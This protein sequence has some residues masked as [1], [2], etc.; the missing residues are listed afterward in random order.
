MA[1]SLLVSGQGRWHYHQAM[2]RPILYVSSLRYSSWS[3]RALLPLLHARADVEV[4]TVTLEM[5]RQGDRESEVDAEH[6]ERLAA[7]RLAARRALG[8]VTGYFPVLDVDGAQIHE[9]LAICEWAAE[10]YPEAGLWPGDA[11]A[12]A[13][14]RAL[15]AEMASNFINLRH[16]MSCHV[17]A[18]VPGFV[19][20]GPTRVEIKRVFELMRNA[21]SV[22][23]G[24]F[25]FGDFSIVDA[26]Y[27]PVLTRFETYGVAL[28]PELH[29][30]ADAMM[31]SPSVLRWRELARRA[32]AIPIYSCLIE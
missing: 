20:N 5:T 17:F 4:K 16:H 6:H 18:R 26:M 19:P 1:E 7:E 31:A 2:P 30:Y 25:L 12:R 14:A 15:S 9:A 29:A 11:L 23:G 21:L 24:P 28:P 10:R 32:P 27:F 13:R 3:T 22:S 8:S